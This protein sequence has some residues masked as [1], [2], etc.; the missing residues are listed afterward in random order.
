MTRSR[1]L[2]RALF[3]VA[4]A[5]AD[6]RDAASADAAGGLRPVMRKASVPQATVGQAYSYN[7]AKVFECPTNP[8]P[9]FNFTWSNPNQVP[10]LPV[11]A[12]GTPRW[13]AHGRRHVLAELPGDRCQRGPRARAPA[14]PPTT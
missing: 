14:S 9:V 11:P 1:A 12:V 4:A 3:A 6:L 10:G 8:A 13:H 5:V 7:L 2:P